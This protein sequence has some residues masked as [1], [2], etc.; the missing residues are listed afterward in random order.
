MLS[1]T[2]HAHVTCCFAQCVPFA[3]QVAAGRDMPRFLVYLADRYRARGR[4]HLHRSGLNFLDRVFALWALLQRPT[5]VFSLERS[6]GAGMPSPACPRHAPGMPPACN[7]HAPMPLGAVVPRFPR[8]ARPC[9]RRPERCAFLVN[10]SDFVR[11]M[12]NAEPTALR[13]RR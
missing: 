9:T 4:A 2:S 10:S 12:A 8:G 3:C 6:R 5:E 11:C 13:A 7:R 1:P